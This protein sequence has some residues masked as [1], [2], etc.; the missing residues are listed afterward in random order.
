[1]N[2]GD[3]MALLSRVLFVLGAVLV[4]QAPETSI[5][6]QIL[7][8]FLYGSVAALV[9]SLLPLAAL[10][11]APSLA[12]LATL[13]PWLLLAAGAFLIP[14]TAA[15]CASLVEVVGN[16]RGR[17]GGSGNR[18]AVYLLPLGGVLPA[19]GSLGRSRVAHVWPRVRQEERASL[20]S[21]PC[22][23]PVT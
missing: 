15:S 21:A 5:F 3:L 23:A 17:T 13:A 20:A 14:V 22:A 2:I 19:C 18:I 12:Q 11:Q 10:G 8:F 16:A 7:G 6:E 9:L 4:R 1:M